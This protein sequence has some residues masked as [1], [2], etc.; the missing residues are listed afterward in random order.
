MNVLWIV[1]IGIRDFFLTV[2]VLLLC[3]PLWLLPWRTGARLGRLYGYCAF[4]LWPV[5]RRTSLINLRR[6]YGTEMDYAGTRQWT[7]QIFGN[8]GQSIAEGI[9]FSRR[10]RVGSTDW[11]QAYEAEDR[12]LELKVI[13]DPR[14]KVFVTGH[15]GSWE[16]AMQILSLRAGAK[17]AAVVRRVDNAFLNLLVRRLRLREQSQWIEKRG[18]VAECLRRLRRGDSIAL[19]FDE[20]G[21]WRGSFVDFFGRVTSTRKTAA[22][23][24]LTTGAPIVVGAAIRRADKRKF[25]FKLA[26]VEP[27]LYGEHPESILRLTQEMVKIYEQWVRQYPLQWRWIHWRWKNQPGGKEETYTSRDLK[28]CFSLGDTDGSSRF[29]SVIAAIR[30]E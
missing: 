9:Q 12:E 23:L 15:L 14:P 30:E 11:E 28:D 2:L 27:A 4:F 16:V 29:G 17:G 18:A 13:T 8:L 6:A 3:G 1:L 7:W 22:L 26:V 20:N 25:L 21:G 19:L 10:F 24:S 5:A